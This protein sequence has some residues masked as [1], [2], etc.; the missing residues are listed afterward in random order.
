M[1]DVKE[2][3]MEAATKL[4]SKAEAMEEDEG[5]CQPVLD[6]RWVAEELDEILEEIEQL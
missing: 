6:L 5:L 3:V 1:E 2:H 4:R